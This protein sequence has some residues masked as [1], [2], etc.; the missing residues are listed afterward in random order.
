MSLTL[1][2]WESFLRRCHPALNPSSLNATHYLASLWHLL[3]IYPPPPSAAALDARVSFHSNT[4]SLPCHV[5]L[6]WI[7][8]SVSDPRLSRFP[9]LNMS[10]QCFTIS[11]HI[12]YPICFQSS[13]KSLSEAMFFHPELSYFSFILCL[14]FLKPQDVLIILFP[15]AFKLLFI[16]FILLSQRNI[17][18][19]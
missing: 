11:S 5:L 2:T 9:K 18:K 16:F 3:P 15:C 1:W 14:S 7:Q 19:T 13:P 4:H 10:Y 6:P 8:S 12:S 17:P